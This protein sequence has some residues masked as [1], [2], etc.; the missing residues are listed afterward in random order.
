MTLRKRWDLID[1]SHKLSTRVLRGWENGVFGTL[2]WVWTDLH[3]WSFHRYV[4]GAKQSCWCSDFKPS[5]V[6]LCLWTP[7]ATAQITFNLLIKG[8][9][10]CLSEYSGTSAMFMK[11]TIDVCRVSR[12]NR[13]HVDVLQIQ[14]VPRNMTDIT[15]QPARTQRTGCRSAMWQCVC[16]CVRSSRSPVTFQRSSRDFWA[17]FGTSATLDLAQGFKTNPKHSNV[18]PT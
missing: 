12:W 1:L 6:S 7:Q 4:T 15:V 8:R 18:T 14:K 16:A 9:Q 3:S 17:D 2:G 13:V 10:I 11:G 5:L